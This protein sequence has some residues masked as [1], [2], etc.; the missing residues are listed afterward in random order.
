MVCFDSVPPQVR[1]LTDSDSPSPGFVARRWPVHPDFIVHAS[2]WPVQEH[3]PIANSLMVVLWIPKADN[4]AYERGDGFRQRH[5]V[6]QKRW[7]DSR[8][9]ITS[10]ERGKTRWFPIKEYFTV[11]SSIHS[12]MQAY[13]SRKLVY[14]RHKRALQLGVRVKRTQ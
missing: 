4:L 9:K 13:P 14:F 8:W 1:L 3:Q 5:I 10:L 7:C 12:V 2:W 11:V 6:H